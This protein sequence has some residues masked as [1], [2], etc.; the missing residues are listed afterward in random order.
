MERQRQATE[1]AAQSVD[2]EEAN[3]FRL[4]RLCRPASL[5]RIG[6]DAGAADTAGWP[7]RDRCTL[8]QPSEAKADFPPAAADL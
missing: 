3:S 2:S 6:D 8:L 7:D 4:R 1:H 5:T